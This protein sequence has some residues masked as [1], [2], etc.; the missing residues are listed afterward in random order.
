MILFVVESP[1]DEVGWLTEESLFEV[2]GNGEWGMR[3]EVV[4]GGGCSA[5]IVDFGG[6]RTVE[7]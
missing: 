1:C 5:A 7:G 3:E 6:L 4:S 2:N